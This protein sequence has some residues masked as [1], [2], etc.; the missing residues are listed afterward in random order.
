M[1]K[2]KHGLERQGSNPQEQDLVFAWRIHCSAYKRYWT[3][4]CFLA[5]LEL[6]H[7]THKIPV[8]G[9]ILIEPASQKSSLAHRTTLPDHLWSE[10]TAGSLRA[11]RHEFYPQSTPNPLQLPL[12]SGQLWQFCTTDLTDDHGWLFFQRGHRAEAVSG[13]DG[14]K[15]T[16]WS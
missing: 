16:T 12:I 14:F 2:K 9:L 13:R 15:N 11:Q 5:L 3:C 1:R 7:S 6:T 8:K 10:S 4:S